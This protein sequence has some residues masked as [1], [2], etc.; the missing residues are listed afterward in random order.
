MKPTFVALDFETANHSPDS[1]CAIGLVRVEGEQV[2]AQQGSLIRPPSR[3]F[4]FTRIHGITWDQVKTESTFAAVWP[5]FVA[6]LQGAQFIAAHNASFD[7]NV[8]SVCLQKAQLAP[9]RLPFVCTLQL[10]RRVLG[11]FP[12]NLSAVA[13]HLAVPLQHHD[14]LSDAHACAQ[15]VIAARRRSA[16]AHRTSVVMPL[17]V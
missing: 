6:L 9:P 11:I 8:L 5:R 3:H 14:A 2:V 10:A 16:E 17:G 15:I 13:Q 4:A 7:R 1:A 12:S